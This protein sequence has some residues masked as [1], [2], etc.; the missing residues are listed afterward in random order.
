MYYDIIHGQYYMILTEKD[1]NKISKDSDKTDA[2]DSQKYS[3]VFSEGSRAVLDAHDFLKNKEN[4]KS[5]SWK[6]IKTNGM[7]ISDGDHHHHDRF[8]SF[9]TPYVKDNL[10]SNKLHFQLTTKDKDDKTIE[11]P[12]VNVIVKRVY[13][14]MIFQG[15]V[16]LGAY[17]AGVFDA[18]VEKLIEED[19]NNR[20]RELQYQKRPL[21]DIVAGTSIG[22]MNGAIVINTVTRNDNTSKEDKS[23]EEDKRWEDDESWKDSA[24]K[25]LQFWRDQEQHWPTIDDFF[26]MF[27]IYRYWWDFMHTT[28]KS[29]KQ[30]ISTLLDSFSNLDPYFKIWNDFWMNSS[31]L[32][33]NSFRDFIV[34]SWYIPATSE[35]ARRYYSGKQFKTVG[36]QNVAT[37]VPSWPPWLFYG[38]FFDF[39]E[40]L[41]F[42]PRADNK[43][44][45]SNSLKKT[46]ERFVPCPI[47]TKEGQ[48]RFLAVTVDVQTG[49][50]VTFDSYHNNLKYHNDKNSLSYHDGIEID[51][52][53]ASG[54]FPDF[55]DYP[56]FRV[57]SETDEIND[58]HIFWDGGIQ[59]NTPLREVIQAHRDYWHKTRK[60][61]Q[62]KK[63]EDDDEYENNVPDLEVY[64]ADLWPSQLKEKPI[65]FDRDFVENRKWSILFNDKTDHDEQMANVITDYVDLVKELRNLAQRKGASRKDE[66]KYIFNRHA[67]SINTKGI[68]RKYEELLEGRFR[69]TKVVRIDHKDDGH[70]V[71]NKIFDYSPKTIENMIKCG[72][73]DTLM[74]MAI[75]SMK[76]AFQELVKKYDIYV[77]KR[78]DNSIEK[79]K[80]NPIE[81]LQKRF[82]DI[83][84]SVKNQNSYDNIVNDVDKF[85]SRVE[86]LKEQNEN[87]NEL[88][89]KEEKTSLIDTAKQFQ[90]TL[91]KTIKQ[92]NLISLI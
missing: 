5:Y 42:I 21:F 74:Q 73:R 14:A 25:V 72:Y 59:S 4:V 64:I 85:I 80:D 27:P 50:P 66:I 58:E 87:E 10:V 48:P 24:R 47:R 89:L 83:K 39:S 31:F 82:H 62:E 22:A 18:L 19:K 63:K 32:D 49:D 15:G 38:K 6:P 69:L 70:D 35:S 90:E 44:F 16:A 9:T 45:V 11:Q 40:P 8:F 34:D 81:N 28:G 61:I 43:H 7:K 78:E 1:N 30:A 84:E 77:E 71:G 51:H 23:W 52:I 13:R 2:N 76:E 88:L 60:P 75:Q 17:E 68:T 79:I 57:N 54:T 67:S 92:E 20:R 53:L 55:F 12:V 3:Y 91:R 37:G 36:A 86:S 56:R 33:R 29:S 26:N 46:L 65:S 41:N